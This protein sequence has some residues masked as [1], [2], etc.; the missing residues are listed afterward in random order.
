MSY[1]KHLQCPEP[2]YHGDRG[3]VNASFRTADT[4]PDLTSAGG[5][6]HHLATHGSTGGQFGLYKPECFPQHRR[7]RRCCVDCGA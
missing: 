4:P 5:A 2:R 1:P 7:T 6:T 3:E